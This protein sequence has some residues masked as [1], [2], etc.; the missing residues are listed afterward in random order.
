MPFESRPVHRSPAYRAC[1]EKVLAPRK[2]IHNFGNV[3]EGVGEFPW[4]RPATVPE[5]GVVRRD[6]VLVVR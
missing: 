4:I 3:V 1:S 6:E 5:T 2:V